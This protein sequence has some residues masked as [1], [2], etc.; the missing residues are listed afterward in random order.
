MAK[1][2]TSIG[3]MSGTSMDGID[4]A[5]I[6]TDGET[7]EKTGE[8][9][10]VPYDAELRSALKQAVLTKK[11]VETVEKELTIAHADV[12]KKLLQEAGLDKGDID[13]IGFHGHTID[14]KPDEGMTWQI[15]DGALLA[16]LT[17]VDVVNDFR[18]ADMKEGG[19]GAPFA[20]LFHNAVVTG[21][22]KPAVV[23]N[24][25]G[26]ANATYIDDKNI[27][28]F[29]TGPGNALID[30]LVF[31]QIGKNF[32]KGGKISDKGVIDE[33]ALGQLMSDYYFSLKPP[34]SLDRN[35]FSMDA[36]ANLSFEDAAAT[37]AAFTAESIACGQKFFPDEAKNWYVTGGGRYN[38]K[39]MAELKK[40]LK[41]KV[42]NIEI[43]KL[44]GDAIEAQAFAFLAV[45]SLRKLPLS[46]PG[47]TGVKK[48]S[49]TG[50][51][52]Y[53]A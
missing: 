18:S 3:L 11:N 1:M 17:G 16:E 9:V 5:V 13:I 42:H 15:G 2:L 12:V 50:G 35:H 43:L 26:V 46:L 38:R 49:V 52:F 28:A 48:S 44:N 7:I 24:I 33:S 14:H 4:A 25:G 6:V 53:P 29:D 23:L 30:D 22:E 32:D 45:R 8:F 51:V 10:S 41:G 34:K 39:I 36:V 37:L 31:K 19:Q 21:V 47:T 20:P 27:I 40:R